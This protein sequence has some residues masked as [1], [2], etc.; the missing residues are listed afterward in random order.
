M[1]RRFRTEVPTW[2][3]SFVRRLRDRHGLR[4]ST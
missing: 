2:S 4:L 3:A 1:N